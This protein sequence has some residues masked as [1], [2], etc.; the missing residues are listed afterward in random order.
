[1]CIYIDVCMYIYVCVCIYIHV[2]ED[3]VYIY[4]CM[5]ASVYMY[6]GR[7]VY[8]F[9]YMYC[10]CLNIWGTPIVPCSIVFKKTH[11][12]THTPSV[13]CFYE[14]DISW[15][16]SMICCAYFDF[17]YIK[18]IILCSAVFITINLCLYVCLC[19]WSTWSLGVYSYKFMLYTFSAYRLNYWHALRS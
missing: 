4:V 15:Y 12:H 10:I 2:W 16:S 14:V 17:C 11:S 19:V 8:M 18:I 7:C 13:G 6:M 3:C 9:P 5:C 1:M